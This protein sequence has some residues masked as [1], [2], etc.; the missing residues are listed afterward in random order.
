MDELV[1]D[2]IGK[3]ETK[4][5]SPLTKNEKDYLTRQLNAKLG[6]FSSSLANLQ[7]ASTARIEFDEMSGVH[8][9]YTRTRSRAT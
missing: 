7:P 3:A 5:G 2:Y 8:Y 9:N 6:D 1:D 4:K